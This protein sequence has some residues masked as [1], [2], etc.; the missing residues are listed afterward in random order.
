MCI[1]LRIVTRA[2]HSVNV[3]GI[4]GETTGLEPQTPAVTAKTERVTERKQGV[5][6]D[7]FSALEK[8]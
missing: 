6:D 8:P 1:G 2:I 3:L 7:A 5:T 4:M